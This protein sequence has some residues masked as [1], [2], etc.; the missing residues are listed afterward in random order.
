MG[1]LAIAF[2]SADFKPGCFRLFCLSVIFAF[3]TEAPA[4]VL[5][6]A[7]DE[8]ARPI[9]LSLQEDSE[10]EELLD[11]STKGPATANND[12]KDCSMYDDQS[13]QFL[14]DM[15]KTRVLYMVEYQS[16]DEIMAEEDSSKVPEY[17]DAL[18]E[19][20]ASSALT[21]NLMKRRRETRRRKTRMDTSPLIGTVTRSAA[22]DLGFG[23]ET[24][25]EVWGSASAQKQE[26]KDRWGGDRT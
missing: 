10:D 13:A 20:A 19:L 15:A 17:D 26:A 2:L 23:E 12:L 6:D 1:D 11:V 24:F 8:L 14:A 3:C 21:I 4:K 25:E 22:N 18:H 9:A 16:L 5:E 7:D